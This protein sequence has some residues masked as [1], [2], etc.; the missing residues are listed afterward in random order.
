MAEI[1]N[2][3]IKSK[4]NKD[5][6]DRLIPNG[7]YRNAVN[8]NVSKSEGPDVGAMEN[9]LGNISIEDFDLPNDQNI[10][11]IGKYMDISTDS[12]FLFLT[13][14]TDT[15][16]DKL[17]N[18]SPDRGR[19]YI[20]RYNL[21]SDEY[22][23]LI[24]PTVDTATNTRFLNFSKTHPIDNVNL[25]EDLLFWT[26]NRNQPRKIN[27]NRENGYYTNEDQIS[28]AKYNPYQP[29]ELFEEIVTSVSVV[30]SGDDY[31][32][33]ST[34]TDGCNVAILPTFG[35]SGT[36]LTINITG[37]QGSGSFPPIGPI[38][39]VE[40]SNPGVGYTDGQ[41]VPL[42]K[43]GGGAFGTIMINTELRGTLVNKTDEYY[44]LPETIENSN[45]N[46]DSDWEGDPDF[47]QDKFVRF[48]YRFLFEDGEYS[49]MAPF[50]QSCF[51]PKQFGYFNSFPNSGG[52]SQ[53]VPWEVNDQ[54]ATYES[55][56]VK[57]M[58]NLVQQATFVIPVPVLNAFQ[59]LRIKEIEILYKDS[60][61]DSIKVVDT[62][63][64]SLIPTSTATFFTYKSEKPFKVLPANE[65]TRV[66]D[67][68]PVRA[69]TQE[70]SGNRVMYGNYVDR[71]AFPKSIE[72]RVGVSDKWQPTDIVGNRTFPTN[73]SLEYP[74]HSVK[75][76]RNYQVGIVLSDRYGRQSPVILSSSSVPF[77]STTGFGG[78]TIFV[79]YRNDLNVQGP[80]YDE[81]VWK[82]P[83]YS[84][85]VL[86]NNTIDLGDVGEWSQTNP[87]GWYSYKVVVKQQEQE[88]YNVYLP[89]ILNGYPNVRFEGT[90]IDEIAFTPLIND[91]INKIPRR[92]NEVGPNQKLY[93]SSVIL[94]GRVTNWWQ[95]LTGTPNEFPGEV[96]TRQYNIP[97]NKYD[98]AVTIG[99]EIDLD[100][101]AVIVDPIE[102]YVPTP[103][104]TTSTP[105]GYFPW[106]E[107]LTNPLFAS[108]NT[109]TELIDPYS[110]STDTNTIGVIGGPY[111]GVSNN[112]FIE[113]S[114][115]KFW[116]AYQPQL[117]VYET[118]PFVSNLDIYWETTSAGL[119]SE[120]NEAIRTEDP[121]LPFEIEDFNFFLPEDKTLMTSAVP[122]GGYWVTDSFYFKNQLGAQIN[123][124]INVSNLVV[125]DITF[126]SPS[127]VN[128]FTL[129]YDGIAS[130]NNAR[131][132][133]D[134]GAPLVFL[135]NLDI[136]VFNFTF[137]VTTT[138]GVITTLS[139]EGS[140]LN[141]APNIDKFNGVFNPS[142]PQSVVMEAADVG[143]WNI[144]ASNGSSSSTLNREELLL[145]ILS[146]EDET[147]TAIDNFEIIP[148]S[149]G[150][151][152]NLLT[153]IL[154]VDPN[155]LLE[156]GNYTVVIRVTDA[157]GV[158][159]SVDLTVNFIVKPTRVNDDFFGIGDD[160]FTMTVS[161][162]ITNTSASNEGKWLPELRGG[163]MNLGNTFEPGYFGTIP[164]LQPTTQ[165]QT[166][167]S[168]QQS[169]FQKIPW[170]GMAWSMIPSD[171]NDLWWADQWDTTN[172]QADGITT[173]PPLASK[174]NDWVVPN[175][176]FGGAQL[177]NS[178]VSVWNNENNQYRTRGWEVGVVT[179]KPGALADILPDLEK[180]TVN[181]AV[182]FKLWVK[183]WKRTWDD[184]GEICGS[185]ILFFGTIG[186]F[187]KY[188]NVPE[189]YWTLRTAV[190]ISH[191]SKS[192]GSYTNWTPAA[193]INGTTP[194]EIFNGSYQSAPVNAGELA[195]QYV[196]SS[197]N[198]VKATKTNGTSPI[199]LLYTAPGAPSAD[200]KNVGSNEDVTGGYVRAAF[201]FAFEN[202]GQY[203]VFVSNMGAFNSY[204][205]TGQ[206]LADGSDVA[207]GGSGV[208]D[209]Q[210][211]TYR[212][213][214]RS[215]KPQYGVP[216]RVK[217]FRAG[218]NI[219]LKN[220]CTVI[221][222]DH[223][224]DNQYAFNE[225]SMT[226]TAEDLYYRDGAVY[227]WYAF[228]LCTDLAPNRVAAE[229]S[230]P[231][232]ISGYNPEGTSGIQVF[233]NV[234]PMRYIKQ[235]YTRT[236][237]PGNYIYEKWLPA[238]MSPGEE[239]YVAYSNATT[240]P[241]ESEQVVDRDT[242]YACTYDFT[243]PS[244]PYAP[245]LWTAKVDA[246]GELK[247]NLP[248]TL[249][250]ENPD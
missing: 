25:I 72:Y 113:N 219:F 57:F 123:D 64:G 193:D 153:G 53:T 195:E 167:Y 87:L 236:G 103:D 105:E 14:Y 200:N 141:I 128:F 211:W 232:G 234:G 162:Q 157:N 8:I 205:P 60:Q 221:C 233:A 69:L 250:Y 67:Q 146:Q 11:I 238:G 222:K 122:L 1:K 163:I 23:P 89:G 112:S 90:G 78:D 148:I 241:A 202:E 91:N 45:S 150:S 20:Y 46:Y 168:G 54:K 235:F 21:K 204:S 120:L 166:V 231:D 79:P 119:I 216:G 144:L 225:V 16:N 108:I 96:Y 176:N 188:L 197:L 223:S 214:T 83:G 32:S 7:E 80:S 116:T 85:K 210:P 183:D 177:G 161:N 109:S 131:I 4:M 36:G 247:E 27:I 198:S 228:N 75:Q 5:L 158:G 41:I 248:S 245:R 172:G 207:S 237:S 35:V 9:V 220:G 218:N 51:I 55:T 99:T 186:A 145:E 107:G 169:N 143:P 17:S 203:R 151:F 111:Y 12:I 68:V 81:A 179:K 59:N 174:T 29:I 246:F 3:F 227:D 39:S 135:E 26:D 185:W 110:G 86:F 31:Q 126:P 28:V 187:T 209:G 58:E 154:R 100:L 242:E 2:M 208:I 224:N 178:K 127:I 38:T 124:V 62:I 130:P 44:A 215:D 24:T 118:D 182:E 240:P 22:I 136:R 134:G 63:D 129:E 19:H 159:L 149:L 88:Y 125:T 56:I 142:S 50:T 239:F 76:N 190:T 173:S 164:K 74:N 133:V 140:L 147:F 13:D 217:T 15:S 115:E 139:V 102:N 34:S 213:S 226:I 65:T 49:L 93:G 156:P 48:S 180:G 138:S 95:P 70:V 165:A 196:K 10:S 175:E 66:Y 42:A 191:R 137:D 132:R 184:V 171:A 155:N 104:S 243:T 212:G 47:L 201:N 98:V 33:C 199:T 170:W 230:A 30:N 181:V 152:S 52:D 18:F 84:L 82:W 206:L 92:L 73:A 121:T 37:V 6:D 117:A 77:N 194:E 160:S 114:D 192:G 61:E 189:L 43:S 71:Q 229:G 244:G 94:Y 101:N 40:V 106:Y 249:Y 97:E